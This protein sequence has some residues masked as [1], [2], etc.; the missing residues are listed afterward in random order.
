MKWGNQLKRFS[1]YLYE[2]EKGNKIRNIG[3]VKVEG[4]ENGCVVHIYGQ[5]LQVSP[6]TRWTVYLLYKTE[7]KCVGI[8]QGV[9]EEVSPTMRYRL[10]YTAE[11]V[12]G[13]D[14]YQK[15]NGIL[16]WENDHKK[17]AASWDDR[18][19]PIE[20]I[21]MME[22]FEETEE[23]EEL[24][25]EAE[26]EPEN[27]NTQAAEMKCESR[28]CEKISRQ[29]IARLPRCEWRIANNSF[30]LHGYYNYHH[31]LFIEEEEVLW[32]GVPGIYHER[33][34]TAAKTFGFPEFIKVSEEEVHLEE[35]EK[36]KADAFGYWCRKVKQGK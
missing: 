3:F 34:E 15:V 27:L 9:I 20:E 36:N 24:K 18:A 25:I 33:E 32:L 17:Y 30:L 5:G 31:L 12:G 26:E 23:T 8:R 7:E 29:D 6:D 21:V 22:Q 11:D 10:A 4:Q 16:L 14:S 2:Y 35:K 19:I 28:R 13:V 1:K